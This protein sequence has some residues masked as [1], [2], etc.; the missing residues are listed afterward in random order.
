MRNAGQNVP[1]KFQFMDEETVHLR[2]K[3]ILEEALETVEAMG[4]PVYGCSTGAG[5][6]IE[7]WVTDLPPNEDKYVEV[8]DGLCDLLY[9]IYGTFAAMGL[10][11]MPFFSE[12]HR[13][14]VSKLA[15]V[16]K[17]DDGKV[18]KGAGFVPPDLM[19]V[20]EEERG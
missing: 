14:N 2:A 12:V 7:D 18:N 9:V 13:S 11:D 17:R 16:S 20:L 15:D 19:S 1:D 6:E 3:L 5:M 10:D 8:I 4:M